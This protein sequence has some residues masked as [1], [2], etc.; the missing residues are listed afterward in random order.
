MLVSRLITRTSGARSSIIRRAS[1]QGQE[2]PASRGIRP[3]A[4]SAR[5]T[6]PR[7][8]PACGSR[9]SGP[10]GCGRTW[11]TPRPV[12]TSPHKN[13]V[14]SRS[15]TSSTLPGHRLRAAP[16][17]PPVPSQGGRSRGWRRTQWAG[18][19]PEPDE[20]DD[21]GLH[22]FGGDTMLAQGGARRFAGGG[23]GEQEMLTA[24]IAVPEPAGVLLGLHYGG[25]GLAGEAFEHHRLPTRRPYL[26][27]TVCLVTPSWLAISCQDHPSARALST[28]SISSRSVSTRSA[29]TARSPTSGSLLAAPSPARSLPL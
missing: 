20:A 13:K 16:R 18:R 8:S 27:C 14:S 21:L 19:L 1:P 25:A 3:L 17:T 5:R 28:W 12:I 22:A 15:P 23:G 10:P 2:K 6:Y 26:R 29:A 4:R 7:A 9:S 11:S 24:D